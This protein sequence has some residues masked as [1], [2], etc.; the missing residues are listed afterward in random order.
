MDLETAD[1]SYVHAKNRA[2]RIF[3]VR[4]TRWLVVWLPIRR[5]AFDIRRGFGFLAYN[6]KHPNLTAS[7]NQRY[8]HV[9]Q[10]FDIEFFTLDEDLSSCVIEH[11]LDALLV[12]NSGVDHISH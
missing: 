10:V 2:C 6:A 8:V 5:L 7:G 4:R 1:T 3:N 12:L 11:D 9:A